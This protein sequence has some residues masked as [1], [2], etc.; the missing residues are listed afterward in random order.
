MV[1]A[2]F[3]CEDKATTKVRSVFDSAAKFKE[4]SLND[5]MHAGP[6][7][8]NGLADILIHFRSK[9]A[10]LA[11]DIFEMFLKVGLAEK[12]RPCLVFFDL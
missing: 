11:G 12:D 8:Q 10:A 4:H 3:F 6:K 5:M 2:T 7:L 9:P 1:P